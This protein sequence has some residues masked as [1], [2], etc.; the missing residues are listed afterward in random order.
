MVTQAYNP[1]LRRLN[2]P[3]Q[4]EDWTHK[5]ITTNRKEKSEVLLAHGRVRLQ[6]GQ[7]LVTYMD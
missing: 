3:D 6:S 5:R 1:P 2:G 4:H 7:K